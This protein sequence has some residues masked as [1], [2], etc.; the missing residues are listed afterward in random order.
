[1]KSDHEFIASR[2]G[3]SD[4]IK[5]LFM[6]LVV[7]NE[8]TLRENLEEAI[9]E[10]SRARGRNLTPG[11]LELEVAREEYKNL[12]VA[13][14]SAFRDQKD[15]EQKV[16]LANGGAGL[17]AGTAADYRGAATALR[18]DLNKPGVI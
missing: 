7:F 5:D 2:G 14:M 12:R 6:P 17:G 16:K 18:N 9:L 4:K 1:M 11:E 13:H 15:L 8:N 10:E 3:M